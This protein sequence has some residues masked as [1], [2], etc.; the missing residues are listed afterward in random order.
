MCT[1]SWMYGQEGYELFCNRD[2]RHTRAAALPPRVHQFQDISFI[3]PL[4]PEGGGSWIGANQFGVT[5]CLL[6]AYDTS[7]E[8]QT[9][10]ISRGRLLWYLMDCQSVSEISRRIERI[11]MHVFRPLTLVAL[12]L[13]E[14]AGVFH[15]NGTDLWINRNGDDE[16]PLISS[17]FDLDSVQQARRNEWRHLFSEKSKELTA[18]TLRKFHASHAPS[19][20]PYSVCMHRHDARTVSFTHISV[21]SQS[22]Q[23]L[24][25]PTSPC[26]ADISQKTTVR[27]GKIES[28]TPEKNITVKLPTADYHLPTTAL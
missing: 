9:H 20:S 23:M 18:S 5:L 28:L 21:N 22:I 11:S 16:R 19:P 12:S 7:Q 17:S 13:S 15:W 14:K 2:E 25:L 27:I 8:K 3:S 1:V 26:Q 24:Y 4:D 6:N 10:H